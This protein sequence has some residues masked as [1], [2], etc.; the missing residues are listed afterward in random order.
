MPSV[1]F[2]AYH[3]ENPEKLSRYDQYQA[4]KC[5]MQDA[6]YDALTE[7]EFNDCLMRMIAHYDL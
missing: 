6:V 1:V 5:D 4:I 2:M 7:D 3:E